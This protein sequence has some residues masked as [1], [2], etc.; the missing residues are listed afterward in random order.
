MTLSLAMIVK[1]EA[2]YLPACLQSVQGLVDEIVIVDTGSTDET[3]AIAQSY[4]AQVFSFAWCDDFAAA[5]N[6]ALRR[7]QGDWV[8]VLDAD[9]VLL[10]AVV[11]LIQAAIAQPN[12]L[13]VNLVRQELGTRQ[14]PYTLVSRLFRRHPALTF[15]RPYHEGIDDS[16]AE[17]LQQQPDWQII[18]LA[19]TAIQHHGYQAEV[20]QTRNKSVTAKRIMEGYL[21]QV[22]KD[23]YIC[24]KLGALYIDLG[25]RSAGLELLQRGLSTGEQIDPGTCYELNYHLGVA[26]EQQQE[27]Q[28]ADHYYQ[29]ALQQAIAPHFKLGAMINWAALRQNHGDLLTAKAIYEEV[30]SFLPDSAIAHYNLGMTLKTL[31]HV[32][33]AIEHY[34]Q[35]I[36]LQPDYAEAHQNLGVVWLKVGNVPASVAAFQQ[37]IALHQAQDSPEADRLQ[38]ALQE[39]GLL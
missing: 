15:C 2:T 33:Q 24:S 17:L 12:H 29:Q 7:V 6:D 26:Y 27:I 34:Q 3:M 22:P 28:Q 10:P 9:E 39:M 4:G 31:G 32:S 20:I 18:Q 16:V 14:S 11:P 30:L 13:V 5:R 37:A 35:A 36:Q 38:Q 23:A 1:N 21:K 8:L 19:E 25:D